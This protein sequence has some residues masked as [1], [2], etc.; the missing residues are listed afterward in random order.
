MGKFFGST[1]ESVALHWV[2]T[3]TQK[4]AALRYRV[5]SKVG[6]GLIRVR[7]RVRI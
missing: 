4:F 1:K 6:L 3:E 7:A 5:E 2:L